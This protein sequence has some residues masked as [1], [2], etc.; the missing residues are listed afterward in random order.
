MGV[1]C[2]VGD[3]GLSGRRP[4]RR[5]AGGTA[6]HGAVGGGGTPV[7]TPCRQGA[8]G[9]RTG[10]DVAHQR[11]G[12]CCGRARRRRWR[13]TTDRLRAGGVL[14]YRQHSLFDSL[15]RATPVAVPHWTRAGQR[16]SCTRL[17]G[18]GRHAARSC[19][20][21]RA[22]PVH[23]GYCRVRCSRRLL[24]VG[25]GNDGA[26]SLPGSATTARPQDAPAARG[27][28]GCARRW[29]EPRPGPSGRPH[30]G[31]DVHPRSTHGVYRGGCD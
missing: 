12:D 16:Q 22:A 18:L 4:D 21:R 3:R 25:G 20:G 1:H 10:P 8:P 28:R 24:A 2:G 26:G 5:R 7:G 14:D 13:H 15:L 6:P 19:R 30:L 31:A 27:Q 11:R 23:R 9:T 29:A 17:A